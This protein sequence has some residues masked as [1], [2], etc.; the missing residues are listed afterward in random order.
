MADLLSEMLTELRAIR[1]L[2]EEQ[3]ARELDGQ[4]EADRKGREAL[5]E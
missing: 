2:L 1:A 3:K 5:D 4:A